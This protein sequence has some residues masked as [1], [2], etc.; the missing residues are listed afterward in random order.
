MAK[1]LK[2]LLF[3]AIKEGFHSRSP[4][5]R[6][7]AVTTVKGDHFYGRDVQYANPTHGR[8]SQ[9]VAKFHTEEAARLASRH[10]ADIE[11]NHSTAI[12]AARHALNEA[13]KAQRQEIED[14][15]AEINSKYGAG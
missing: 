9:I 10:V 5:G 13:E 1:S 4:L 15:V 7:I 8:M 11:E 14:Y 2:T 6:I 3:Y 12:K